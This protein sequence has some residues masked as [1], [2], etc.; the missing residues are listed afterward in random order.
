[1]GFSF[2]V[3]SISSGVNSTGALTAMVSVAWTF[4]EHVVGAAWLGGLRNDVQVRLTEGIVVGFD[5]APHRPEEL[6]RD[7][8]DLGSSVLEQALMPSPT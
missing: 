6:V 1:V 8:A 7:G 4:S 5:A 2:P 3:A